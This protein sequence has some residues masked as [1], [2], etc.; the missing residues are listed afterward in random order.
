M[1][2]FIFILKINS[3]LLCT[4]ISCHFLLVTAIIFVCRQLERKFLLN[5]KA[6]CLKFL[7]IEGDLYLN[8]LGRNSCQKYT[9]K[10]RCAVRLD[11][12]IKVPREQFQNIAFA[13]FKCH[14]SISLRTVQHEVEHAY[15]LNVTLKLLNRPI[16][17]QNTRRASY[18]RL[19]SS[20][21]PIVDKQRLTPQQRRIQ[22][23]D[24]RWP[25]RKTQM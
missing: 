4:D 10:Q 8:L 9:F 15:Y 18:P 3:R 22:T 24:E 1:C 20:R 7:V 19:P 25:Q 6:T 11:Q 21:R 2:L 16:G 14:S 23:E 12:D 13:I 5:I 17:A